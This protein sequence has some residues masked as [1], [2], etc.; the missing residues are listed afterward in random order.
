MQTLFYYSNAF[1]DHDT[2]EKHVECSAR[3]AAINQTILNLHNP[4]IQPNESQLRKDV[5]TLIGLIH[6]RDTIRFILNEMPNAGL[7]Y[8]DSDTVLS[9]GSKK[10]AF[11]AVSA[12]C[13]AVD[14]VITGHA[15]NAFCASRPP[16]HHAEPNRPMGFC[17]FN[18][19]A[20]AAK[21]ALTHHKLDRVAIV[22]FDVHHGN[23]TQ[24]AFN[25]QPEV[26]FISSHQWPNYPGSGHISETGVGNIVN[27]NL[28]ID[29]C[30][31]AARRAYSEIALPRLRA[32]NP[33]LIL[34]SAGFDAHADDPLARLN[35]LEPDYQWLTHE[36]MAIADECCQG[37]VVSTLEGGYNVKALA[38]CVKT[39]IE[40]LAEQESV[41]YGSTN[42]FADLGFPNPDEH[43][44]KA[45]LV[46]QISETMDQQSLDIESA[47]ELLGVSSSELN[48]MFR[49]IFK[50]MSVAQLSNMVA[51][52]HTAQYMR[53]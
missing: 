1:L 46:T 28:P 22:D 44:E 24:A 16:G 52:L 51:K 25:N 5:E 35:W 21:Y 48:H 10:A 42:I 39:H 36:I 20:I 2:G 45:R 49:G 38:S 31:I 17:L 19:V 50:E 14:Q 13:D 30:G 8:L 6:D 4:A 37:R 7:A 40:T 33:Q 47:A 43:L 23:G 41:I 18:N 34:I 3:I 9:P 29:S 12:I 53:D 32:F 26:L 27:I 11:L 15:K